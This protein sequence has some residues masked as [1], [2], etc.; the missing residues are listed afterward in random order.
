ME[1]VIIHRLYPNDINYESIK[2]IRIN[3]TVKIYLIFSLCNMQSKLLFF[4]CNTQL[5]NRLKT[6]NCKPFLPLNQKRML[7]TKIVRNGI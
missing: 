5:C 2:K 7:I 1:N 3:Y 4:V 6:D